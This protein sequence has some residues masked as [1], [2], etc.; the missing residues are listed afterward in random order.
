[1]KEASFKKIEWETDEQPALYP[2]TKDLYRTVV[3]NVYAWVAN[4]KQYTLTIPVG[5]VCD[6]NSSPK[7]GRGIIRPDGINRLAGLIHD[8][9]YRSAGNTKNFDL[10]VELIRFRPIKT[11]ITDSSKYYYTCSFSRKQCDQMYKAIGLRTAQTKKDRR[12][13]KFSYI[14]LRIFGKKHFGSMKP[15]SESK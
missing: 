2:I 15:P 1:V 5:F 14:M 7:I 11:R 8:A 13:I 12:A 3:E 10:G 6:G 9:L 4:G